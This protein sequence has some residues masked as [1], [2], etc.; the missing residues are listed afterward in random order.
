MLLAFIVLVLAMIPRY[1]TSI[2]GK[3]LEKFLDVHLSMLVLSF[4]MALLIWIN[5]MAYTLAGTI[6]WFIAMV[7]QAVICVVLFMNYKTI[8]FMLMHPRDGMSD[9][10]RMLHRMNRQGSRG[11]QG[12]TYDA[13]DDNYSG[14]RHRRREYEDYDDYEPDDGYRGVPYYSQRNDGMGVDPYGETDRYSHPRYPAYY[15]RESGTVGYREPDMGDRSDSRQ[16]GQVD[17]SNGNIN[18]RG[19]QE[20]LQEPVIESADT[21]QDRPDYAAIRNAPSGQEL[22]NMFENT[23]ANRSDKDEDGVAIEPSREIKSNFSEHEAEVSGGGNI[24]KAE[25]AH[26]EIGKEEKLVEFVENQMERSIGADELAEESKING[27]ADYVQELK[28]GNL[29]V[30]ENEALK[31]GGVVSLPEREKQ[32]KLT[33]VPEDKEAGTGYDSSQDLEPEDKS[34]PEPLGTTEEQ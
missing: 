20:T 10:N 30:G 1:G 16:T 27:Y 12:N 17:A 31:A 28:E 26:T 11:Y 19:S 32:S 4:L 2:M 21:M 15:N 29:P 3:W 14:R 23:E 13:E 25:G 22:Y 8:L 18:S 9:I 24:Q 33:E 5:K 6:G 7:L 34:V